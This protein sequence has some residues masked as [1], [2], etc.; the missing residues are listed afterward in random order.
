MM[1]TGWDGMRN[2]RTRPHVL[3]QIFSMSFDWNRCGQRTSCPHPS[4]NGLPI[5]LFSVQ[6]PTHSRRR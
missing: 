4:I 6:W 5:C 1:E 3:E 2:I